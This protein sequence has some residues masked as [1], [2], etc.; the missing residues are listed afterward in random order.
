MSFFRDQFT[1]L[2]KQPTPLKLNI[3]FEM[4]VNKIETLEQEV[5][6]LKKDKAAAQLALS[7]QVVGVPQGAKNGESNG[8]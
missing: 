8:H 3:F 4:V 5:E 1:L 6:Q 2:K 7:A